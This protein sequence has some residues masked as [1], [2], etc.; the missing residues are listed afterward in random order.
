MRGWGWEAGKKVRALWKT[1]GTA[2]V[3]TVPL[4]PPSPPP[5]KSCPYVLTKIRIHLIDAI[6]H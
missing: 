5:R 2:G 3:V 4:Y 1:P 6:I